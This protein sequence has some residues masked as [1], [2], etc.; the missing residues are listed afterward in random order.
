MK[1]VF[2]VCFKIY[3]AS[4]SLANL[5]LNSEYYMGQR[6]GLVTVGQKI[7]F[8]INKDIKLETDFESFMKKYNGTFFSPSH[9]YFGTGIEYKQFGIIHYCLHDLDNIS[10]NRYPIRNKF[11]FQW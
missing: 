10:G 11:Y 6:F 1:L 7:S 4:M 9:I 5:A 3:V 8:V 2:I